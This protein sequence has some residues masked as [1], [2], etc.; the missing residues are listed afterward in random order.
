MFERAFLPKKFTFKRL[1]CEVVTRDIH[2]VSCNGSH[3][4]YVELKLGSGRSPAAEER[5]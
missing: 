3:I 5:E 1:S 2:L 4:A